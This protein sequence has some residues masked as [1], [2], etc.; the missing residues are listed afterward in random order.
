MKKKKIVLSIV[1]STVIILVLVFSVILP[2]FSRF[3]DGLDDPEWDGMVANSF[4]SGTGTQEDPYIIS[5]PNELA[6]F[7][8]SLQNED[9]EGKY[10]KLTKDMIINKGIFKDNTYIYNDLTYYR[11]NNHKYYSDESL[12]NE[13][14]SINIFPIIDGFKGTF[15]GDF[16]TIYGIYEEGNN[17]NALFTNLE[18]EL[19]NLYMENAYISGGNI[20]AGVVAEANHAALKNILFS[21]TVMGNNQVQETTK[22]V[23]LDN[24]TVLNTVSK[25]IDLPVISNVSENV[26]IGTCSGADT[27]TLNNTVYACSNFEIEVSN[28]FEITTTSEATFSNVSYQLTYEENKTSGI[29]GVAYNSDLDGLVNEGTVNGLY[30]SGIAGTLLNTNMKNSYNKGKVSGTKTAGVVPGIW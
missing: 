23:Q 27:F 21:G 29:V 14:G 5:T 1:F 30:S 3:Q 6:Y 4:K 10:I 22:T 11:G 26:L 24:F 19:K 16:H 18:G 28:Q 13:V 2:T 8:T 17:R 20:T 7:A 25:S 15:D 12:L 9:Y